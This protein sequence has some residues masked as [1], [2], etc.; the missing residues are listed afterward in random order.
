M[1]SFL[2]RIAL[3]LISLSC[4]S[5]S[6]AKDLERFLL[7]G[8]VYTQDYKPLDS[9]EVSLVKDDSIKVDFKLL[10]GN[11]EKKMSS[12]GNIRAMVNSGMGNYTL[13]LYKEG[14]DPLIHEFKISSVSEEVKYLRGLFMEKERHVELG[15]VTVTSTRLKLVMKGDTLVYDAAAFKLSEGS[16]LDELVRQLPGATLSEDGVIEVNGRKI[17]ELLIN[18]KDFFKGDPKVALQNLPSYTVKN[19]KVY[20]KAAKDAYLT[21]SDATLSKD[22]SKE[23]L[24]MDVQLKKE[25]ETGWLANI[26]AGY[27]T[28][29]RYM[30]RLFG[31]GYTNKLR[32]ATYGNINNTGNQSQAGNNG[33]WW[34]R[35]SEN[36][37]MKVGMGGVDYSYK[38]DKRIELSGNVNYQHIDNNAYQITAGTRFFQS[39]DLYTR[40]DLRNRSK[41]HTLRTS[42]SLDI[43]GDNIY[44][45]I[46]PSF[47]WNKNNNRSFTRQATFSSEPEESYRGQALDSLFHSRSLSDYSK[48]MLTRLQ[49]MSVTDPQSLSGGIRVSAVFAPKT[50]KGRLGIEGRGQ[51]DRNTFDTHTLLDQNYG[52]NQTGGNVPV[53][54]DNFSTSST[55][56]RN[57]SFNV[58]YGRSSRKFGEKKTRNF[59]YGLNLGYEHSYSNT[60]VSLYSSSELPA[61]LTPPS[62][63]RPENLL[64]DFENSPYTANRKNDFKSEASVNFGFE[65]TAP[66]DSTLNPSLSM[67]FVLQYVHSMESYDFTKPEITDQHLD[68]HTN[69]LKPSFHLNFNSSNKIRNIGAYLSYSINPSAPALSYLVDNRNTSDPLNI[70]LGNPDGLSNALTHSLYFSLNRFSRGERPST[71]YLYFNWNVVTDQV[72]Q[73]Q[74]YNPETGVTIHKPENISGNWQWNSGF[75]YNFN[76]D[77]RKQSSLNA[78]MG[79]RLANSADYMAL[80]SDFSRN[81]VFSQGY[82]PRLTYNYSFKNG[83]TISTGLSMGIDKQTAKQESF[84]NR[85][86]YSYNPFIRLMLKLPWMLDFNT[87]FNPY[88]RRGLASKEMNTNEYVWNATLT[89]SF[90]KNGLVL[91][92][93]A[94]DILASAKHVYTSVN[95]QGRTET[96]RNCLPRYVMF[97][98][99]YRF[100]MKPKGGKK[101]SSTR[102]FSPVF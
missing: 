46:S 38:D 79:M 22:E 50:W 83:S 3:L 24:V 88:F 30:G 5:S 90:K 102:S 23:N 75:G 40:N 65:P 91:K 43:K 16:M 84:N 12:G 92:L 48:D 63:V 81:S 93:S 31:M 8:Y 18:G 59:E 96:W 72:A 70:Y 97:S 10:I 69:F 4:A 66:G 27:G 6:G 82:Y 47:S 98:L 95:A 29:G 11:D 20:D 2:F 87:Q 51:I 14:Y 36:G 62:L 54:K 9:V 80:N 28:D 76:L 26:E 21:H 35:A 86:W 100:D 68:R 64:Q 39:G 61:E 49:T 33:Q 42:H 19:L 53:K 44:M 89:K 25:Y 85:T 94:M 71:V 17:N 41:G 77:K 60:D 58:A 56:N 13:T 99:I 7:R 37:I 32:I 52:S 67:G 34:E 57:L 78:G 1:K 101:S 15:N 45:K 73:S 55:N 74:R